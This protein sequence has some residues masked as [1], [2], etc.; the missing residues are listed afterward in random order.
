MELAQPFPQ[1]CH[2]PCPLCAGRMVLSCIEPTEPGYHKR[3]FRC[4]VCGLLDSIT[5]KIEAEA[6]TSIGYDDNP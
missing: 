5:V 4:A 2:P 3:S 6:A 1:I